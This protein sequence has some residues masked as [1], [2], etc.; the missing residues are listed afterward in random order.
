MSVRVNTLLAR[1]APLGFAHCSVPP[2][3]PPSRNVQII[4]NFQDPGARI[5]STTDYTGLASISRG[6]RI[7]FFSHRR[8]PNVGQGA[9][10]G[11]PLTF[12][13][14]WTPITSQGGP[15]TL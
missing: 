8:F 9:T 2:T 3:I 13:T 12:L 11:S 10:N 14:P 7:S 1:T 5:A 15:R 4:A 6:R